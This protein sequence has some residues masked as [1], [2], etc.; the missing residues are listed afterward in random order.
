MLSEIGAAGK[1]EVDGAVEKSFADALR[2]KA[3][4]PADESMNGKVPRR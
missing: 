1:M 2:F 3:E 4:G